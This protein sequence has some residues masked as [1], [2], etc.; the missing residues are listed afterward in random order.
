MDGAQKLF[1]Q[2]N[3]NEAL[4]KQGCLITELANQIFWLRHDHSRIIFAEV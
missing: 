3:K 2:L 1:G 4:T